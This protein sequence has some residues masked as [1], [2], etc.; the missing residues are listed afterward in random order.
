MSLSLQSEEDWAQASDN[1]QEVDIPVWRCIQDYNRD[2]F[3][4][5]GGNPEGKIDSC[6]GR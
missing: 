3:Q 2:K 5:C 6:Q 1:L 4:I